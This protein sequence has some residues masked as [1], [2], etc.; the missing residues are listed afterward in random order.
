[1]VHADIREQRFPVFPHA[2]GDKSAHSNRLPF[3]RRHRIL[4]DHSIT[5]Y[6]YV[7]SSVKRCYQIQVEWRLTAVG[8]GL[9]IIV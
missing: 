9:L 7:H 4:V 2:G 3:S 8:S 6:L 1:M 5:T